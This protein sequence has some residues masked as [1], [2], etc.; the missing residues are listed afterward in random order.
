MKVTAAKTMYG[1][2]SDTVHGKIATFESVLENRFKYTKED[3]QLHLSL[4]NMVEDILMDLFQ[5]RFKEVNDNI[6][7]QFPQIARAH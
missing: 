5:N 1:S 7:E 4:V 3:W 6:H 2:L